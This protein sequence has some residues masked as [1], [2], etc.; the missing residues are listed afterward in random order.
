MLQ[1]TGLA[2]GAFPVMRRLLEGYRKIAETTGNFW[3]T[4]LAYRGWTN[5]LAFHEV[6]LKVTAKA[7]LMPFIEY[8]EIPTLL[9]IPAGVG[10]D[11][12]NK[13]W[14][15]RLQWR[16]TDSYY[17]VTVVVKRIN[18]II[19]ELEQ[20]LGVH[21]PEFQTSLNS[22]SSFSIKLS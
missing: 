21:D 19:S 7:M 9:S 4:R 5:D 1:I 13:V 10:T 16:L 22:V 8:D 12:S 2:L 6:L 18:N 11:W 15:T 14:E 3:T 17:A 20:E